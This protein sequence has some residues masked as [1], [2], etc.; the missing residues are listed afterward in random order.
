M[1]Q[2]LITWEGHRV[3]LLYHI[4]EEVDEED[5]EEEEEQQQQQRQ[6]EVNGLPVLHQ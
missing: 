5:E 2:P 6:L 1:M 3:H 4:K